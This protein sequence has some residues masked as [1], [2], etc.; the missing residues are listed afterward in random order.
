MPDQK[1]RWL[2]TSND[3]F[4]EKKVTAEEIEITDNSMPKS[5][6]SVN[7]LGMKIFGE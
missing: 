1:S 4:R 3:F 5:T 7:K 6:P 2:R